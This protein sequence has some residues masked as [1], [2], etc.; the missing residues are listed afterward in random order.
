[1]IADRRL[2]TIACAQCKVSAEVHVVECNGREAYEMH[3]DDGNFWLIAERY[4][5]HEMQFFC[6]AQCLRDYEDAR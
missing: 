3:T 4:P 2:V 1:M 5:M 6:T